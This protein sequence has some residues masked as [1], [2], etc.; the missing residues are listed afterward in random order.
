MLLIVSSIFSILVTFLKNWHNVRAASGNII[1]STTGAAKACTLI[2]PK[3]EGKLTGMS[4]RVPTLDVSVV[5][6]TVRL[7]KKT[8]YEEICSAIKKASDGELKGILGYTD[9]SFF[10]RLF[11]RSSY[12]YFWWKG[13][14]NYNLLT[15]SNKN[16]TIICKI[17]LLSLVALNM[18]FH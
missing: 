15:H 6:L 7:E 9:E 17:N 5:D 8:S 11:R 1:P 2:L 12:F 18:F 13:F 16:L 3:M 4:M 14:N 10:I